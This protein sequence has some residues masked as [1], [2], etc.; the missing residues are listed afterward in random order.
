MSTAIGLSPTKASMIV[1]IPTGST[2]K[3]SS[4]R[5]CGS[6][7]GE[8]GPTMGLSSTSIRQ[9]KPARKWV[10]RSSFDRTAMVNLAALFKW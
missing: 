6:G 7:S 8:C 3:S 5:T 2:L 4:F 1:S 10:S 9:C